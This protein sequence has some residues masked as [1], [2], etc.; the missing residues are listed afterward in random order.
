[1]KKT[2]EKIVDTALQLF[3]NYGL[4]KVTLRTI[5]KEMGISQ[6]NLNYHYKKRADIIEA[7]YF[8]LVER[9][10]KAMPT[11]EITKIDLE[12]LFSLSTSIMHSS[13]A[14]RFF[15]LDFVQIMREN[16]TI[17][18]HYAKLV[19]IRESQFK[20]ILHML[21]EHGFLRKEKL[22]N[23]YYYLYKRFHILGDFW[24]SS[25]KVTSTQLTKKNISEYAEIITQA[26]FP[27]LTPKGEKEYYAL[28]TK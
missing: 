21:V 27:Y 7:L 12:L 4:A 19:A 9:I 17:K 22:P 20:F 8:Q 25:A 26:I 10:D 24:I 28:T 23:E 11:D 13:Y 16:K 2:N 1:M 5:A 3:N 18:K 14:Y 6:G 15:L